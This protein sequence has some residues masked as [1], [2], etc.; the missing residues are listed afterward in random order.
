MIKNYFRVKFQIRWLYHIFPFAP[1]YSALGYH[2]I[3]D[4]DWE[5]CDPRTTLSAICVD[6]SLFPR[7]KPGVLVLNAFRLVYPSITAEDHRWENTTLLFCMALA[8]KSIYIG[9]VFYKSSRATTLISP[10]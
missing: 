9:Y 6:L 10:N 7:Q 4:V 2:V 1:L 8:Y 3:I 5:T